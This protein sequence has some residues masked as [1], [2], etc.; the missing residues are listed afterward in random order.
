MI[1]TGPVKHSSGNLLSRQSFV[2]ILQAAL[3]SQSFRFARQAA[4]SWLAVYPGDLGISYLLARALIGER[5]E[6]QAVP[7]LEKIT[8][9]D[10]EFADAWYDLALGSTAGLSTLPAAAAASAYALGKTVPL[11]TNLPEWALSLKKA[12]E[13]LN[14]GLLDEAEKAIFQVIGLNL[15]LP[16]AAV[17]HLRLA[18]AKKDELTLYRLAGLYHA[19]WPSCLQF[20]LLLAQSRLVIEDEDSAV[21]LLHQCVANDAEGSVPER[22]W[23]KGFRFRS[24]WP[25]RLEFMMDL[26]IPAEVSGKL[27]WNQLATGPAGPAT[28]GPAQSTKRYQAHDV[29]QADTQAYIPDLDHDSGDGVPMAFEPVGDISIPQVPQ[30]VPAHMDMSA[31]PSGATVPD[32]PQASSSPE[33]PVGSAEFQENYILEWLREITGESLGSSN[34]NGKSTPRETAVAD[35]TDLNLASG[36][37]NPAFE[38]N[39]QTTAAVSFGVENDEILKASS[40]AVQDASAAVAVRETDAKETQPI[41][42]ERQHTKKRDSGMP[43]VE[44]AFEKMAKKL[45]K[46]TLARADGRYPMYVVFSTKSGLVKQYGMQTAMLVMNEMRNLSSM[47][48]HRA[49]WGSLVFVPDDLEQTQQ[50]GMSAVESIDPW[51]LKLALVDLDRALAKKGSM[52][53]AVLIVGGPDAVPFHK[54]PNPTDDSDQEVLSDNPYATLDSNYF[55]PE[56]PVGRLPGEEGPDAGLLLDQL[57]RAYSYHNQF[58]QSNFWWADVWQFIK[59]IKTGQTIAKMKATK[60]FA[61][62]FGYTAAVWQRS[63]QAT[64]QPVGDGRSMLVSPPEFSGSFTSKRI[65][66]S[67]LGYYNL[68]GLSDS[69]DWYGQ[70]DVADQSGGPDY[71]VALS[72]KDLIKNGRAPDVVFSEACYGSYIQKKMEDDAMSL[73]FLSIGTLVFCGSTTI[74]YGSVTTPLIGADL[75]G[76]LFWKNMKDGIPAGESMMK[77]KAELAKEMN[78]RQGFLDGEDQKTLISFVMYGDPLVRSGALQNKAK[79]KGIQR[80]LTH[81]TVTT[82]C[83]KQTSDVIPQGISKQ[84]LRE[85]KQ[86]VESYL[87]GLDDAEVIISQEH[88]TCD[89]ENHV[90]PTSQL[91]GESKAAHVNGRVVVTISKNVRVKEYVHKHYARATLDASGKVVKLAVSR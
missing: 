59:G 58:R 24:L 30:N 54:L 90:C 35:S 41:G 53:G 78:R 70:R 12:R 17:L 64:Y 33:T 29:G 63:S 21:N 74:A 60:K 68:H 62:S 9:Y 75:L 81:F 3:D 27:G 2:L 67:N 25:D 5:K 16:L 37:Q 20:S 76:Y 28:D 71:P 44:Q 79:P 18:S 11:T 38:A 61:G 31:T 65:T 7:I 23:G 84:M 45:K 49:G 73:K 15:D 91:A 42:K 83:D 10:P 4:L 82:V 86:I 36:S 57:R 46:G 89:G 1:S 87:P 55:I 50:L 85:V 6:S 51:K 26:P 48:G 72:T 69:G 77:A 80:S 34:N 88:D 19:R 32:K 47:V 40:Q 13:A 22:L 43:E 66:D 14:L 39:E 8:R 52:I 56:W